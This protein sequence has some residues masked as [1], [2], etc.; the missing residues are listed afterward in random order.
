[1]AA[2]VFVALV[3]RCEWEWELCSGTEVVGTSCSVVERRVRGRVE[4]LVQQRLV[5]G[6]LVGAE[7]AEVDHA[8]LAVAWDVV[9]E[10]LPDFGVVWEA[11]AEAEGGS[12]KQRPKARTESRT[13]SEVV[14]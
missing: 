8:V 1:M 10:D 11:E 5:T 7:E 3:M 14:W 2:E 4:R 13:D 9:V 6:Q 12:W